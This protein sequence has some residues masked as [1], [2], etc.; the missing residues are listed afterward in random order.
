[1]KRISFVLCLLTTTLVGQPPDI[2]LPELKLGVGI[3]QKTYTNLRATKVEPDGV[4]FSHDGGLIKVPYEAL[5][6]EIQEKLAFDP[7][8]AQEHRAQMENATAERQAKVESEKAVLREAEA[9][10]SKPAVGKPVTQADVKS[11]WIAMWSYQI[12]SLDREVTKKREEQASMLEGI[13]SGRFDLKASKFAHEYNAWLYRQQGNDAAAAE[14]M[15][16]LQEIEK[17]EAMNRMSAAAN[18]L[19][20]SLDRLGISLENPFRSGMQGFTRYR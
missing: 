9:E 2:T 11:R 12:S 18:R 1:M 4:R 10:G 8:K 13:R 14:E 7:A 19:S 6:K 3:A 5:P 16:Q 15:R 17:I 20:N